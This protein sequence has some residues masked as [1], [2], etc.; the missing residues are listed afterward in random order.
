MLPSRKEL[1]EVT[2][3][4]LATPFIVIAGFLCTISEFISGYK[5]T[6]K[7]SPDNEEIT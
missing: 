1:K 2:R 7:I 6:M 3:M 5:I 4:A